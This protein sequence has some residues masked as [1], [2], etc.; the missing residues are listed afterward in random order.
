MGSKILIV[1]DEPD[2]AAYLVAV[3]RANGCTP[4]VASNVELGLKL[5]HEAEPDVICLDIMMPRE[6]GISLYRRLR[7]DS[8]RRRIPVVIVSGVAQEGEFDFRAYVP[9]E[10]IPPPDSYFEKPIAVDE[11]VQTVKKLISR[12]ESTE[13]EQGR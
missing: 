4:I 6:S 12:S 3:L 7:A 2:V 10:S 13:R 5:V 8:A 9:D 11:F 1:E